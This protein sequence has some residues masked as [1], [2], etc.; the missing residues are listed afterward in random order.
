MEHKKLSLTKKWLFSL[1]DD[2]RIRFIRSNC[3]KVKEDGSYIPIYFEKL[4]PKNQREQQWK[5]IKTV[6]ANGR[7]CYLT[8]YDV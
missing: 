5:D 8:V 6:E 7:C 1:P 4:Y 3:F 2:N